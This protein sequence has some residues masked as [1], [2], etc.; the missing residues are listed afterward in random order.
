VALLEVQHLSKAFSIEG[1]L[2]RRRVGT[3]QALQDVS[4][5]IAQGET[6]ALV[7]GSGCGKSTLA[8]I[9]AGLIPPDQGSTLWN[10]EPL[11]AVEPLER[12]RRVQMVFQ[13]PFASLNPKLSVETQLAE[14]VRLAARETTVV[15][16]RCVELL[17]AVGLPEDTLAHYPFQF[18]GGQR[19]RIAI[20]RA[21]AMEPSLLI[22][23]EPLSSLDVTIQAQVLALL[24]DL[25]AAYHLTVLFITHD[26]AVAEGFAQHVVVLQGG[27][28]V[29]DGPVSQ[30]LGQPQHTYTKALLEAVP[31]IS[32]VLP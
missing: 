22:A 29:E 9:I 32:N 20:A 13:D 26:L 16:A 19:Q 5:S 18:S 25:K 4:L 6:A 17:S 3:V 2:L 21:L 27:R 15:H 11:D 7:G 23:D 8:K 14:V 30:V 28:V 12:A 31:R 1:G 24:K 10:G